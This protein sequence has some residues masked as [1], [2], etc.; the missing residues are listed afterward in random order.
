MNREYHKWYSP[1]LGREM[2]LLVFG[3]GGLPVLV[4]PT[5]GGRFFEFEDRSMVA[6]LAD[7]LGSGGLQLFCVDSVDNESWYNRNVPPRWRIARHIQFEDY[8]TGEVV[9]LIRQKN[10]DAHLVALGCSFGGYHAANIAFRHPDLFTGLLSMSGA[11]EISSFLHGYYDRDCYFHLPT[12]YLP[13][14]QDPW[15]LERFRRNTYVLATGWDDQCLE[16]N[17]TMDRILNEKG[18]PHKL[19]IWDSWNSHDWPTWQRMV[20]QYL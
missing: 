11:F 14:M 6:A 16:Q 3:H 20:Q 13:G 2:E 7:R 9:P 12:H 1:R 17:R 15:Y 10:Q 4:F 8:L 19:Y 18:I 5:S